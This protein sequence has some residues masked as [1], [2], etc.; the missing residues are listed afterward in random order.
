MVNEYEK[1]I[2]VQKEVL[3]ALPRNN[4]KNNKIYKD[5]VMKLMDE[6][7]SY[8]KII[9][10]EIVKRRGEYVD[11]HNDDDIASIK[12]MEDDIY[13]KLYL[14]N[15]FASSYEKSSLDRVLYRLSHFYN[16]ELTDINNDI[17]NIIDIFKLMGVNISSD[18]FCY[19]YYSNLYMNKFFTV[20]DEDDRDNILKGYFE[21]IYWKCPDV[22]GHITLN[23]K[24]LYYLN[25][26]KFD[27]YYSNIS[28]DNIKNDYDNIYIKREDII[29]NSRYFIVNDF[30]SGKL[31]INNYSPDKV[32]K[33]YSYI[34][35][36][37]TIS[38]VYLDVYSF[39]HV[40]LEYKNYLRF[41]YIIDGI[42]DLYKDKDKYKGI[43]NA[44]KK[45]INKLEGKVFKQNRKIFKLIIKNKD[46]KLDYYNSLVNRDI[47][48]LKGLYDEVLVNYFLE[49]VYLLNEDST[50]Y[51]ILYLVSSNYNYLNI[52]MEKNNVS[53]D[54]EFDDLCK[55]ISWPHINVLSNILINDDR[56]IVNMIIDK[57]NL[58]G[59]ELNRDLFSEGN[60]DIVLDNIKIIL[61]SIV[62]DNLD[63]SYGKIKFVCETMNMDL[64]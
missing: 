34:F 62:M 15:P 13:N 10:S 49:R 54:N 26:N 18:D 44:K 3:E 32:K 20:Y 64:E 4:V 14:V 63:I 29:N 47:N 31:D 21:E 53:N 6:Y 60:L 9:S 56:D 51:D 28:L 37:N 38:D 43:Y 35:S 22:I 24:Y 55:F 36:D 39:Y 23:F 11:C 41:K 30:L 5:K 25:K 61:N 33:A 17:R 1:M 40:I 8:K 50:L 52:L 2:N 42:K 46:K 27:D 16:D 58:F 7:N 59:F 57:Y 45:E 48:T 19:S 12:K